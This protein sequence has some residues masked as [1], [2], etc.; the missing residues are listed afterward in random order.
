MKPPSPHGTHGRYRQGGCRCTPCSNAHRREAQNY[1]RRKAAGQVNSLVDAM[2]LAEAMRAAEDRGW[3]KYN[4]SRALEYDRRSVQRLMQSENPRVHRDTMEKL[5][6]RLDRLGNPDPEKLLTLTAQSRLGPVR[7]VPALPYISMLKSLLGNGHPGDVVLSRM[8]DIG[9]PGKYM[10]LTSG[11]NINLK[12]YVPTARYI[13][14][15]HGDLYL[16]LGPS[17]R[18]AARMYRN[19]WFPA[20]C[21]DEDDP[22]YPLIPEA[23]PDPEEFLASWAGLS[24]PGASIVAAAGLR[25]LGEPGSSQYRSVIQSLDRRKALARARTRPARIERL[26]AQAARERHQARQL[27]SDERKARELARVKAWKGAQRAS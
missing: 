18:T 17:W 1:R 5:M 21:Y 24:S 8:Q 9:F 7:A 23:V 14:K 16:N 19:G 3:S 13:A 6:L 2:P 25:Q 26:A 27:W 11:K 22:E 10:P 4:L 15:T 12:M 20:G